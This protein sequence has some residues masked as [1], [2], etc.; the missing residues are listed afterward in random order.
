MAADS[1]S[2]VR[3]IIPSMPDKCRA[4][5]VTSDIDLTP[6]LGKIKLALHFGRNGSRF[7]EQ[8]YTIS[9][10]VSPTGVVHVLLHVKVTSDIDMGP[11]LQC[12]LKV[13]EDLS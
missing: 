13:K 11:E 8:G 5:E 3:N 4:C 9:S 6:Y 1:K 2:R 10:P 7:R 12:L